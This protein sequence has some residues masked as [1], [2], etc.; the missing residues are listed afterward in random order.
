MFSRNDSMTD[1]GRPMTDGLPSDLV[2]QSGTDLPRRKSQAMV[3]W[4][5]I[6]PTDSVA[7]E[8]AR[9]PPGSA[10]N[11]N[12]L[13]KN[14]IHR[15]I[16]NTA[17]FII[18]VAFFF[19]L[20]PRQH[21]QTDQSR[22][23]YVNDFAGVLTDAT[24]Q[25]LENVLVNLKQKTGIDFAIATVKTTG[26]ADVSDYSLQLAKTWNVASRTGTKKSFVLVV[27]V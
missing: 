15:A 12:S 17:V 23:G 22:N 20:T 3:S 19:S 25:Q 14:L 5:K 18:S 1:E 9:P 27:S 24:K 11:Y 8:K 4:R 26:G 16:P 6:E 13:M 21:A 2:L 7:L 10:S